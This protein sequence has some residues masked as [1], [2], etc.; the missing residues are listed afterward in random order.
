MHRL[1]IGTVIIGALAIG[2]ANLIDM[3]INKT[4]APDEKNLTETEVMVENLEVVGSTL[5]FNYGVEVEELE[6]TEESKEDITELEADETE[7]EGMEITDEDLEGTDYEYTSSAGN[8]SAS[9]SSSGGTSNQQQTNNQTTNQTTSN[10]TSTNSGGSASGG[11]GGVYYI[12]PVEEET[13][14]AT[15]EE[16]LEAVWVVDVP[17][18]VN[19]YPV[20]ETE[21]HSVC[22]ECHAIIDGVASD[23]IALSDCSSYSTGVP[24]QVQVDTYTEIIPEQGHWEYR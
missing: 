14:E 6:T 9:G 22:N 3:D 11:Y 12:P 20:Y 24:F 21:Y 15:T 5:R 13:T 1:I 8:G 18:Q 19:T 4:A 16:E 23:H 2:T 10:Q 17:E 7:Q